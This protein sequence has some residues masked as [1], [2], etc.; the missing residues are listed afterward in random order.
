MITRAIVL[1]ALAAAPQDGRGAPWKRHTI[2]DASR[3]ADGV[4]LADANG[5]GLPDIV[6]G[7]EQGGVVR[8]CLNPGR[9]AAR[10]R[11]PAV[12]V[13]K[14]PSVED[15]VFA[16]L[17]GD[18][19]LDVVSACE[20]GTR[21]LFLH[22]G[23]R[24]RARLLDSEAW[25]TEPLPASRNMQMWMFSL[26]LQLDG[27]NGVDLVAGG[28]GPGASVG[29]WESPPDPRKLEEW[30]WHPLREAGWLMSL[31]AADMDG[32]GDLDVAASDRKG[33]RRGCFWLE[34]PG[35]AR[36]AD[37]WSEHAIGGAGRE[38]M[39]IA[40]GDPD[41]DGL[42]D[43]IVAAKPRELL[44]FRRKGP[45]G[46]S[47]EERPIAT[48]ATAG[49]PKAV[50]VGDVDLDGRPDLVVT[51]EEARELSGVFWMLR[52]GDA[53]EAR[54]ISGVDGVKHDLVE[55]VDLD[56]DGDLDAIACEET[57][58]LGV[59]WYENPAR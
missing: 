56:G 20:G 6:T 49:T 51:C 45:G 40:L 24:D 31:L 14:A 47:W 53:W 21:A 3:G 17:D 11:W 55:L 1:L 37:R 7:W 58:N 23:P 29:W 13:G 57:R 22:W 19:A 8:V 48:P 5:D 12:T 42:Q 46:K 43:L 25:R 18:G 30:K 39:F 41:Q 10:A 15:A 26:P 34:N 2:D 35:P 59:F 54:E 44:W 50:A 27:R 4:R 36:V 32:D 38:V 28:K 16:D 33:A 52:R 9:A